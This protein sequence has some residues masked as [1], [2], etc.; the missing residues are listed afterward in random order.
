MKDRL[1]PGVVWMGTLSVLSFVFLISSL[2]LTTSMAR[3]KKV[4]G[5]S[6]TKHPFI[7]L[8]HADVPLL[9]KRASTV[10]LATVGRIDEAL[11]VVGKTPF[12]HDKALAARE[13]LLYTKRVC[14]EAILLSVQHLLSSSRKNGTQSS[15]SPGPQ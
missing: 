5:E 4:R 7:F 13:P 8:D 10:L 2:P 15:K 9:R 11:D 14:N 3:E 12:M 6:V 1:P